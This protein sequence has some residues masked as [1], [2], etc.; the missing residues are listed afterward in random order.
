MSLNTNP[1]NIFNINNFLPNNIFGIIHNKY[2]VIYFICVLVILFTAKNTNNFSYVF[3]SICIFVIYIYYTQ[4]IT[5][6][7]ITYNQNIENNYLLDLGIDLNTFISKDK[8]LIKLLHQNMY[9]KNKNIKIFNN[10]LLYI[11]DFLITFETLKSN[12]VLLNNTYQ[13]ILLNDIRDK[14][15]RIL[16]HINTFI[17]ILPNDSGYLNNYYNFSQLI[18]SHLSIYYNKIINQYGV[19][20]HTNLY[21]TTRSLENKYGFIDLN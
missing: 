8:Y 16:S 11:E 13:Q 1:V 20:D 2:L 10:L 15:E 19:S 4:L 9:I 3:I 12:N 6:T 5:H 17:Y 18:R 7:N 21:Q 14:L